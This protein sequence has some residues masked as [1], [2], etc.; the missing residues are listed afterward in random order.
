MYQDEI[1]YFG[2]KKYHAFYIPENATTVTA[3]PERDIEGI[4]DFFYGRA[5]GFIGKDI[6]AIT[7]LSPDTVPLNNVGEVEVYSYNANQWELKATFT[8]PQPLNTNKTIDVNNPYRFGLQMVTDG[9]L[10]Y[11]TSS[12]NVIH[13]LHYDEEELM[14]REV[15]NYTGKL[16][17]FSDCQSC[18]PAPLVLSGDKLVVMGNPKL[19]FIGVVIT[20]PTG[21]NLESNSCEDIDECTNGTAQ[22]SSK[23]TC[24]NGNGSYTCG[25]CPTGYANDGLY[26][27]TDIDECTNGTHKCS[28]D[29]LRTCING[30][31]SYTCGD[32]PTGY[33]IS[34]PFDCA[35]ID[36]C[37]LGTHNCSKDPVRSCLNTNG[38]YTCGDCPTGFQNNGLFNCL[39]NNAT[40]STNSTGTGTNTGS[41]TNTGTDT[42]TGTGTTTVTG[43]STTTAVTGT[44]TGTVSKTDGSGAIGLMFAFIFLIVVILI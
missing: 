1:L 25:D 31:G 16:T 26:D 8:P 5:G 34:G 19:N 42:N 40:G 17:D 6:V 14:L 43:G 12:D 13:V 4:G 30:N 3:L 18:I 11:V 36:E 44:T 35:E 10:I 9:S 39:A 23:R 29:P 2:R 22:C 37:T 32:C 38:N 41:G 27:C 20:C 28:S 7:H 21:Y 15:A 33:E 24:I